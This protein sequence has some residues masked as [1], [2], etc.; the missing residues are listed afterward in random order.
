M[1][2]FKSY[3]S[4]VE[5]IDVSGAVDFTT[6]WT[7]VDVDSSPKNLTLTSHFPNTLSTNETMVLEV[8]NDGV[9]GV[10]LMTVGTNSGIS[11]PFSW[12]YFRFKY[13]II[14]GVPTGVISS[15]QTNIS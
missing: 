4:G 2:K 7:H 14:G 15:I 10:E 6:D 5:V 11:D 9:N 13:K 3:I 12:P 8:S 1:S